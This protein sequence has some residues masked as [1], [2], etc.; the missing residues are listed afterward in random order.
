MEWAL[1]AVADPL[2]AVADVGPEVFAVRFQD[3][4]LALLVA[5]GHQILAEILQ[6]PH[7]A[8]GEFG[9]PPD[10]E[11]PGYLPGERHFHAGVLP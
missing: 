8:N 6:R 10:H 1:D 3:V 5:V 7:L 9:R 2:A 11:P 4:Q